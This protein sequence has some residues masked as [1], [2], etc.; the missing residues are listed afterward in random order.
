ML[1]FLGFLVFALIFKNIRELFERQSFPLVEL[2]GVDA[3]FGS[4]LRY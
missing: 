4:D 2:V 3:I 1:G